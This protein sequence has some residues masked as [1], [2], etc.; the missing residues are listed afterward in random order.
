[1]KIIASLS[2]FAVVV[3][4]LHIFFIVLSSAYPKPNIVLTVEEVSDLYGP[5]SKAYYQLINETGNK[6]PSPDEFSRIIDQKIDQA[7]DAKTP[8][9]SQQEK[10]LKKALDF[11]YGYIH[12]VETMTTKTTMSSG[13]DREPGYRCD[14]QIKVI[15]ST[16]CTLEA[17]E[18]WIKKHVDN[19]HEYKCQAT[20]D[21]NGN[22]E[23]AQEKCRT[24]YREWYCDYGLLQQK[25]CIQDF[26]DRLPACGKNGALRKYSTNLES[27]EKAIEEAVS[28]KNWKDTKAGIVE[29]ILRILIIIMDVAAFFGFIL[30]FVLPGEIKKRAG[31]K[32]IAKELGGAYSVGGVCSEKGS[33]NLD[34]FIRKSHLA[35]NVA[36]ES[37]WE[38]YASN[39]VSLKR[40]NVNIEIME[41][42]A[43]DGTGDDSVQTV[44]L[45]ESN[46]LQLPG[47]IMMPGRVWKELGDAPDV[48]DIEFASHPK[49]SDRYLL[50]SKDEAAAR[51]LFNSSMLDHFAKTAG[52]CVEGEGNQ[53]IT[54]RLKSELSPGEYEAF[55][56]EGLQIYK[57][58]TELSE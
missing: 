32:R 1:M 45:M 44:I 35:F 16:I 19:K 2:I 7:F 20:I 10:V 26:L 46:K 15:L 4:S 51:A 42:H 38:I 56:E 49:F 14:E 12:L 6:C 11:W 55:L 23:I 28:K 36:P 40:D 29:F 25:Y 13:Y 31:F 52:L 50:K 39:L 33:D 18:K 8:N 22:N 58:F 57:L 21:K 43:K 48:Q 34:D 53:F 9:R 30:L 27:S 37:S 5:A 17:A 3:I 47:F 54:Y 41:V 24:R